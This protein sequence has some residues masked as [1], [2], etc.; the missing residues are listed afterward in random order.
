MLHRWVTFVIFYTIFEVLNLNHDSREED[1]GAKPTS[2][3]TCPSWNICKIILDS[4]PTF[5]PIFLIENGK[6][7]KYKGVFFLYITNH[8]EYKFKFMIEIF[9]RKNIKY[10]VYQ[11]LNFNDFM[12]FLFSII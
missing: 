1:G 11:D 6:I 12:F 7:W 8:P 2:P 5:E 4:Y 10:L 3:H 9:Y